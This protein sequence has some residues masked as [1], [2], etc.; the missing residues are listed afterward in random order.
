[1]GEDGAETVKEVVQLYLEDTPSLMA[2]LKVSL[3]DGDTESVR[4]VA[5]TLKG[6]SYSVGASALADLSAGLEKL[7]Q[8]ESIEGV[9]PRLAQMESEYL[10][11]RTELEGRLSAL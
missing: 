4:R 11:A 1:M 5:H 3:A 8:S 7:A 9:E 2:E 6:N 10:R